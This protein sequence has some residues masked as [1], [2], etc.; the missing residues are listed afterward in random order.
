MRVV[1][2]NEYGPSFKSPPK[3]YFYSNEKRALS[4]YKGHVTRNIYNTTVNNGIDCVVA[5][6]TFDGNQ[7]VWVTVKKSY[8]ENGVCTIDV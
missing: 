5:L 6:Q 2:W 8:K 7:G 1:I 4:N 3:F